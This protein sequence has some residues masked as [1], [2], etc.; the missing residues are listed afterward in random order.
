MLGAVVGGLLENAS[1]A[2]GMKALL[3]FA[4]LLYVL[5][6]VGFRGLRPRCSPAKG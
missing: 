5:A 4:A 2:V 1:L 3:L 6:G